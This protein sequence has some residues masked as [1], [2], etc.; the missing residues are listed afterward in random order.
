MSRGEDP[1]HG[2]R[3]WLRSSGGRANSKARRN[4][5]VAMCRRSGAGR[6]GVRCASDDRS[7]AKAAPEKGPFVIR[8]VEKRRSDVEYPM[9]VPPC[10]P[11]H[12]SVRGAAVGGS[13]VM[14]DGVSLRTRQRLSTDQVIDGPECSVHRRTDSYNQGHSNVGMLSRPAELRWTFGC[15][16]AERTG[17]SA[18]CD[19]AYHVQTLP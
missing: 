14:G 12:V 7:K 17:P 9:I 15:S 11:T 18:R 1:Q 13:P 5:A 19:T 3:C 16:A 6:L 10:L 2:W 4:G 8:L